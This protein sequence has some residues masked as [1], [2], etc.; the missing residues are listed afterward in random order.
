[1]ALGSRGSG[2][3]KPSRWTDLNEIRVLRALRHT[4]VQGAAKFISVALFTLVLVSGFLGN[5]DAIKNFAPSFVW[6]IWWVGFAY[7]AALI[8]NPWPAMNPWA[9]VFSMIEKA[10]GALGMRGTKNPIIPY[11]DWLGVWPAVVLFGLFAWFEL[12]F[13][14]AKSPATLATVILIYSALTWCAMALFGRRIWLARGDPFS[15][16]FG[17]FGHFAPIGERNPVHTPRGTGRLYLRPYASALVTTKPVSLSMAAFILSMLATV[18]FD[19]FKETSAWSG[20]LRGVASL[21]ALHPLIN[22]IHGFGF[23]L[24][25]VLE[26]TIFVLF[27][28]L[29][30]VVYLGFAWFTKLAAGSDRSLTEIAGLFVFSLV[31][32]AIAYHLAHYLS[33]LLMAGQLIIPLASDPLGRGWDLFF[34]AG[35]QIDITIIGAKSVWHS[36]VVAIVV[37]HVIAVGVAHC[38][39][40]QVFDSPRAAR[41][42]QYPMLVLMVAYTMVSLWILSQPI[43][44]GPNLSTLRANSGKVTLAPFEFR[45][46]CFNLVAHDAISYRF[47]AT[48]PVDFDI[49]Y[50]DGLTIRFPVRLPVRRTDKGQFMAK[51]KRSY[52]L[53]WF[54]R[55]LSKSTLDYRVT[56]P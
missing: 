17:V 34:T 29:F 21:P 22:Q 45:E 1:M 49:H 14:N 2:S 5:Q 23:D 47:S 12:I 50:H 24:Q 32:I 56:G 26:T 46:R 53:M 25:I 15:L 31:P 55:G 16:A 37:G 3:G 8:W 11:P 33:Y 40:L 54:N 44:G 38:V 42:S 18:S 30:L 41:R 10:A 36:A 19:G 39:S 6:I 4:V 20:L 48:P 9:I 27:P 28:L 52:C 43:V 7:I 35:Y 13:E 51:E